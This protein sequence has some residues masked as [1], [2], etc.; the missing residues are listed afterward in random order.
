MVANIIRDILTKHARLQEDA[1]TLA[2]DDDLYDKGLTSLSTVNLMLAIED[3]FDI[4][5]P[6]TKLNRKTFSS[7]ESLL[8]TVTEL[9]K[10]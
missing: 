8:E 7:I 10:P 9:L 3:E 4:E 5:F 1:N 2:L 6:D